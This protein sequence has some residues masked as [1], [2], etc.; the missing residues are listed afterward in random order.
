MND[1][2]QRTKDSM[3]STIKR[4][5]YQDKDILELLHRVGQVVHLVHIPPASPRDPSYMPFP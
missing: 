1:T 5:G 4:T 3:D 2:G